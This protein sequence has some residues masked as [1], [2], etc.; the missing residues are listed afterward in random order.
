MVGFKFEVGLDKNQLIEKAVAQIRSC[1]CDL[2]V[3][4]DKREMEEAGK[5]IAHLVTIKGEYTEWW[6]AEGKEDIATNICSFVNK[7]FF[8]QGDV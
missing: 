2:V 5:H 6:K 8:G 3:A 4:N 7:K 1:G